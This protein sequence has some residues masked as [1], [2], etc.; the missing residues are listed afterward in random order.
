ML[1]MTFIGASRDAWGYLM[2]SVST[3]HTRD[4][5][6][7]KA[8]YYMEH[9]TPAG[10]WAGTGTTA[11]AL[12]PGEH[13]QESQLTALFGAG[14]HPVTGAT[15]GRPYRQPVAAEERAKARYAAERDD[16]PDLAPEELYH[17]IYMEEL[18]TPQQQSVAGFEFVFSP[19]KSVSSWWSLADPHLKDQIRQAHHAAINATIT[20]LEQDMIRTRTGV[21]G[22]AQQHIRGIT[23][24]L[25]DHWDSREGDPQL[26]THMLVSNRVQGSDGKWRTIDSRW[27]L[28]PAVA[29]AG[30]FYD[31]ILMDELSMRFGIQWTTQDVLDYPEEYQAW[32]A[33]RH[34]TAA[35]RHQFS[36]DRGTTPGS[37]RWHIDHVPASLNNEF[38]TRAKLIIR[39][40]DRLIADYVRQYGR[41][42]STRQIIKFRQQAST[43]TR[44]AKQHLSLKDLTASWRDRARPHVGD[45]HLFADRVKAT[46]TRLLN[47]LPLWSYR[48]DDVDDQAVQDIATLVLHHLSVA[49]STW[50]ARNAETESYRATAGWRFRSPADRD[51]VIAR[52]TR[53]VLDR[54]LKL[55]PTS[56]LHVTSRFRT[57]DGGN[58]FHPTTRDLYTTREVWDAEERLLEAGRTRDAARVD[59]DLVASL[60]TSTIGESGRILSSDQAAAVWN[61]ATSGRL[62]DVLVGPAGAGKTT[63]LEKLR[64]LWEAQHGAGSVRGLAPTAR[65]AEELALSLGIDT[66]N[67]AKWLYETARGTT[68]RD[69]F[70]YTLHPGTLLI[71]DEA[72][73]AGTIALDTLCDRAATAGAKLLLVGDWAQLA[74]IDAGGAFGLLATDRDDIAELDQLHRFT[75]DWEADASQLLRLGKPSGLDPYITHGR[76]TWG[77]EETLL[78]DIIHAWQHDEQQGHRSLLIAPDNDTVTRLNELARHW[79]VTR[80]DVDETT[81]TIIATGVASPGDRIVT[82]QNARH[83]RTAMDRWVRNGDEWVVISVNT[84]TGDIVAAA[85][86]ETVTLPADYCASHVELAYATTAHRAQG[87]TVDTAHTIVDQSAT[88]ETFYVAMTRGKHSNRAYVVVEDDAPQGDNLTAGVTRTWREILDRVVHTR[89]GD[90]SAHDTLSEEADRVGSI[91]QLAAEYRTLIADYLERRYLPA[92]AHHGLI[93]P[94]QPDSPYLGPVLANLHRIERAGTN[95]TDTISTLLA[96][97]PLTN[98]RNPLA[99]LHYRL[100]THLAT[101]P[102]P[103]DRIAGLIE[104]AP[105]VDD[106]ELA[107]ALTDREHAITL[108][109]DLLVDQAIAHQEPWLAELGSPYLGATEAWRDRARTV[110]T[111]RELYGIDSA[112]ALG[113][114]QN[115]S[116]TQQ[117]DRKVAHAALA[118]ASPSPAY[119]VS[120]PPQMDRPKPTA[121]SEIFV[122]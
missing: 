32:L 23:A 34:D 2:D 3:E 44:R 71:V 92:L 90:L 37:V 10:V 120:A 58:A 36:L 119:S 67:T 55:T 47:D 108:Q 105:P 56:T 104:A 117:R 111:F 64:E 66:E 78:D 113:R 43:T 93:D 54:A 98:A 45:T 11:L 122:R 50:T 25:F 40:K 91:R 94:D 72:S 112:T 30:A 82:R 28:A 103:T 99:V 83:L 19:P 80:G 24:A 16:H 22:V 69:G 77:L 62:V 100:T 106:P 88:R 81:Q 52:I 116:I 1:T 97:R 70:T 13:V 12:R 38:S 9:G 39:E 107:L 18:Q 21:D 63:A 95:P 48:H 89:G 6:Q 51:Q 79:R 15:L 49:R 87:R 85:G 114:N 42:P 74:A 102:E 8:A 110:A 96:A 5:A 76:I 33:G 121:E 53:E 41:Q 101:L 35:A 7:G 65:A 118:P 115:I 60:L 20:K 29:T 31:T 17:R 61:V 73:I 86:D 59:T 27:S 26:H 14:T 84:S 57:P 75:T 4:R 68:D 109:A 46:G